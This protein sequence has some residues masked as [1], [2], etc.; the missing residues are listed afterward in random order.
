M[1]VLHI[2]DWRFGL[3]RLGDEVKGVWFS[4]THRDGWRQCRALRLPSGG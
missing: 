3:L 2:K 4:V 1:N